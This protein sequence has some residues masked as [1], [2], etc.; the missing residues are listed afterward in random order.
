MTNNQLNFLKSDNSPYVIASLKDI[1]IKCLINNRIIVSNINWE[2]KAGEK[3]LIIGPSGSGK[4]TLLHLLIGLMPHVMNAEVSGVIE[5][6]GQS[7]LT[8][9]II[10]IANKVGWINQDP[11]TSVCLPIVEQEIAMILENKGVPPAEIEQKVVQELES[12]GLLSLR[13][14]QTNT[15][16]GGECQRIALA[17]ILA[18]EPSL[19]LYDEPT[20]MLDTR[21]IVYIRDIL[22]YS[23]NDKTQGT[24]LVEHRLDELSSNGG[25]NHLPENLLVLSEQGTI[26]ALGKTDEVLIEHAQDFHQ[27]GIWLPLEFELF[28]HTGYLGG[29]NEKDNLSFLKELSKQEH[30]STQQEKITEKHLANKLILS[31]S[32]SIAPEITLSVDQLTIHRLLDDISYSNQLV[33]DKHAILTDA[34]KTSLKMPI[35]ILKNLTFTA[36]KGERIAL[37]ANNGAGKSTLLLALA[38]LLKKQRDVLIEGSV[39]TN[40]VGMI[41]QNPEYQFLANTVREE[42]A[43]GIPSGH[44]ELVDNQ[45]RKYRLM[46][47]ASNNPYKLSGGEKRRLS[48]AAMTIHDKEVL[49]ADEPTFGLDRRDTFN[50]MSALCELTKSN[51]TLLFSSHD[52]RLIATY[53]TRMLII[54][55]GVIIADGTPFEILSDE[56]R[57]LSLGIIRPPLIQYL[58]SHYSNE[59]VMTILLTLEYKSYAKYR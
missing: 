51:K 20:A 48:I 49:L 43:Y 52:L 17:A 5:T 21:S 59:E 8:R 38:G 58:M 19:I 7:N 53:A 42:I 35:T 26:L 41:F 40:S 18:G 29:L 34:Q 11:F 50:T 4:S 6:F 37:F 36:Y 12:V 23:L 56:S 47:C 14:R 31:N 46:H 16:S 1:T 27:K 3:W 57:C 30:I 13:Y 45:L 28:A 32:T 2:I 9:P 55:N 10:E 33:N 39:N 44:D 24:I 25:L 22:Q 15:L 54:S